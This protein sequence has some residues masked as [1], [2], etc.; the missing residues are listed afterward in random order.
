MFVNTL[1]A[2]DKYSRS[3]MENLQ[4]QFQ[5]LLSEKQ[6]TFSGLFVAFLKY[7]WNLE[8]FEKR[9]EYARLIIYGIID[10]E[11]RG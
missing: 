6:K 11:K 4:Q 7:A 2:D 10:A 8:R 3:N 1:N 9:D 5:T